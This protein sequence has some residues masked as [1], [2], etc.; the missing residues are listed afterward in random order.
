MN[1]LRTFTT[2]NSGSTACSDDIQTV[3][4][5]LELI[6][7]ITYQQQGFVEVFEFDYTFMALQNCGIY[8]E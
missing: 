2:R 6:F 5:L 4:E 8:S 7:S 3:N 1:L